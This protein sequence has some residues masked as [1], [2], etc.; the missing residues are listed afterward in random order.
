V[1]IKKNTFKNNKNKGVAS[2]LGKASCGVP[3]YY[4]LM[5]RGY[6]AAMFFQGNYAMHGPIF[7]MAASLAT[8]KPPSWVHFKKMYAQ[9]QENK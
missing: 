7:Q 8:P 9:S 5:A 4:K 6:L 1:T 2:K 3:W